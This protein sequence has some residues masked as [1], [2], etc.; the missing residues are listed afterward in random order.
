MIGNEIKENIYWIGVNDRLTDLFE[1]MWPI[2]N[3]VSINSYLILDNKNTLIDI[4]KAANAEEFISQ[5]YQFIDPKDLD[6]VI[7]NHLEP[8]HTGIM[9]VLRALAPQAQFIAS[10]KA[11][12]MIESFYGIKDNVRDVK[13]GETLTLGEYTLQFFYAPWVHWPET[14]VTYET[15][16]KIL[17][18]CDAFGGYGALKGIIFE[19]DLSS[20]DKIFYEKESLRYYANIVAK[21]SRMVLRAIDKLSGLEIKTICPSHGL[22]WRDNLGRIVEL[23]KKWASYATEPGELGITLI[24]ASMYGNCEKLMNAVVR[25]VGKA[26]VPIQVFD[27]ARVHPGFILPELWTKRGVI[28]G[29][30]TYEAGI[31]FPVQNVLEIAM[32]KRMNDKKAAFFGSYGWK[33]GS[34][35]KLEKMAEELRWEVH[36]TFPFKGGINKEILAQGEEFGEKFAESLK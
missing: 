10:T 27:A 17:F 21:Y 30:P 32:R 2:P 15:T 7:V 25:G 1:G 22:I 33:G 16:S 23:Y 6:Y 20:E 36:S 9:R 13:D 8:D 28:V 12:P 19:E 29:S 31:F 5:M 35:P 14:M 18:P 4:T 11:V 34:I 26:G 24:Y 3:G